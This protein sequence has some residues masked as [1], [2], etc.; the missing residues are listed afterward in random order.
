MLSERLRWLTYDSASGMT[1]VVANWSVRKSTI[2]EVSE[3]DMFT[4]AC[5]KADAAIKNNRTSRR[6]RLAF[7]LDN[8]G[9]STSQNRQ[10]M[11]GRNERTVILMN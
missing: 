4:A 10:V 3:Y 11:K 9:A 1:D 6:S 2:L 8:N 7:L 5:A